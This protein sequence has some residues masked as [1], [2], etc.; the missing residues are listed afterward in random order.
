MTWHASFCY[1]HAYT[2]ELV[3][4]VEVDGPRQCYIRLILSNM[5]EMESRIIEA[6]H[7]IQERY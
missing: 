2:V 3:C 1:D 4:L 6:S 7:F 5:L